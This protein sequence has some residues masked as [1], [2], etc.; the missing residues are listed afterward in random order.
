MAQKVVVLQHIHTTTDPKVSYT[1]IINLLF[2][3][4]DEC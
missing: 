3:I 4:Y 1:Y 2:C